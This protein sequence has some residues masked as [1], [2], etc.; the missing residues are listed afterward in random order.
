M[1]SDGPAPQLLIAVEPRLFADTLARAL[2]A[3]YDVV[4][5]D[6]RTAGAADASQIHYDAAVVSDVLPDGVSVD[7]V[8][9]LPAVSSGTGIGVLR[10]GARER[11]VAV[12]G[13]AAIADALRDGLEPAAV[14]E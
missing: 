11:A 12:G 4:V 2:D 8:L 13:L 9:T 7:R 5:T 6:C 1:T 3:E 14:G 10:T